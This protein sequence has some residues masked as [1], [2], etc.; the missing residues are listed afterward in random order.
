MP[1]E[2]GVKS[3]KNRVMH[4][5][6]TLSD[7]I[8]KSWLIGAYVSLRTADK[9]GYRDDQTRTLPEEKKREI[10]RAVSSDAELPPSFSIQ[11]NKE[12]WS[13]YFCNGAIF[14]MVALADVGLKLL[15]AHENKG[16]KPKDD[17]IF[18]LIKWYE[19]IYHAES[20]TNLDNARLRVNGQ[21]HRPR[22]KNRYGGFTKMEEAVEGFQELLSVLSKLEKREGIKNK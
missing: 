7:Q 8:D 9:L 1:N 16:E 20:L 19:S 17:R 14:R 11:E 2:L 5:A 6:V 22:G 10:Y 3:L 13:G 4:L 15:Y 12:W 18:T 21:K